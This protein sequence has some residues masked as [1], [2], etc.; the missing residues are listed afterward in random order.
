MLP[1]LVLNWD[2]SHI[3]FLGVFYSAMGALGLGLTFVTLKS[4]RDYMKGGG[5]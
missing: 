3:I 2:P 1:W 5:H 4:I